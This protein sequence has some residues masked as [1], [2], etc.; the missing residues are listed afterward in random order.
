M[1]E[2][3]SKFVEEAQGLSE[4]FQS[5][6]VFSVGSWHVSQYTCYMFLILA[7]TL[8]V[9]LVGARK[10]KLIPDNKLINTIEYGYNFVRTSIGEIDESIQGGEGNGLPVTGWHE[11][12]DELALQV[13]L[14]R[15]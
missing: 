8:I 4:H 14:G 12:L 9:V 1:G 15:A 13:R 10:L 5:A 11:L 6:T 7:L 3:L 2:A